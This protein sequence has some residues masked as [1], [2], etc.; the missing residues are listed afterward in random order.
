MG[1]SMPEQCS[2]NQVLAML[3]RAA[4]SNFVCLTLGGAFVQLSVLLL[5]IFNGDFGF[6]GASSF[7]LSTLTSFD[8]GGNLRSL[9]DLECS[10]LFSRWER[11]FAGVLSV[12]GRDSSSIVFPRVL[13][14]DEE[15]VKCRREMPW[16]CRSLR[17]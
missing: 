13:V 5:L 6:V 4:S 17:F 14:C 8:L 1:S 3:S 16:R 15:S 9:D 10:S 11:S 2:E 12:W 7:E